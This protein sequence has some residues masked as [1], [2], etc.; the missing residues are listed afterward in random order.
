MTSDDTKRPLSA[1]DRFLRLA[2]ATLMG[3]AIVNLLIGVFLRYVMTEITDFFDWDMIRY[4]WVEEVGE[5]ALAYMTLIGAAVGIRERAHFTLHLG[6]QRLPAGV[7]RAIGLF[8]AV[9]IIGF[10]ILA[11]WHGWGLSLL[12]TQLTS[13]ALEINLAWL[14]GSA[15]IGGVLIAVY[16]VRELIARQR[17]EIA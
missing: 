16:G 15:V 10:G 13:P 14:Y 2:L 12:N 11:A 5:L 17:G 6:V 1:L 4:T 9:L 8:N 3:L 7:Q